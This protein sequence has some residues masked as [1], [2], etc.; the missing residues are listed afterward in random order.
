[1]P[2]SYIITYH[3]NTTEDQ[4]SAHWD[5]MAS[6]GAEIKHKYNAQTFKGFSAKITDEKIV[7]ALREDP[8]VMAIQVN[9]FAYIT[10]HRPCDVNK[11][12]DPVASWGLA[13]MSHRGPLNSGFKGNAYQYSSHAHHLGQGTEIYVI[14]TGIHVNHEDFG[15][16][17]KWGVAYADGGT[18]TDGNGHGTHCAGTAGGTKYGIAKLATLVAVKVLGASGGGT[19][20]DVVAGV[21]YVERTGTLGKSLGSM[22]LGGAGSNTALTNA[23]QSCINKGIPII[24]AAG[25]SGTDACSFT[26]ANIPGVVSV[27]AT[28]RSGSNPELP[29]DNRASWS[30]YGARCTHIFAPGRDITSAWIGSSNRETSTISGTSMACPHV[31]GFA[32]TILS[33]ETVITPADLL[34]QLQEQ[35]SQKDLVNNAQGTP[36]LLLHN[37]CD[38]KP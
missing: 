36:N 26:P 31:A 28:E 12:E 30:N 34:K 14:D 29:L 19:W 8:L 38:Y 23:I 16:R 2:D 3:T 6:V 11:V 32:A 25:N 21:T 10:Q 17:A 18:Q 15:G 9:G 1:V 13:R 20:E 7:S 5:L 35:H 37:G 22:S 24:V 27:A 33:S 4:A